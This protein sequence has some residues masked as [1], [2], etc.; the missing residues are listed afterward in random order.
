MGVGRGTDACDTRFWFGPVSPSIAR[1]P[2]SS[3]RPY[4]LFCCAPFLPLSTMLNIVTPAVT[5]M[6]WAHLNRLSF[7][8]KM[9]TLASKTGTNLHDLPMTCVG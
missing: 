1:E 3:S 5:R 9:K 8:P 6:T 2:T 4:V 7:L